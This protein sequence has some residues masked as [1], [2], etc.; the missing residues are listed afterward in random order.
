MRRTIV[1]TLVTAG[2][3]IP[4]IA[5]QRSIQLPEI[6]IG[7]DASAGARSE[8]C[9]EVEIGN[10]RAYN[11]LNQ[12]LKKEVDRVNPSVN[13]PPVDARSP[14]IRV[15]VVNIP[16][17]QQQY[18]KNFGVSVMPHR[19]ALPTFSPPLGRR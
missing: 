19:P 3:G 6:V 13:M 10:S 16:A 18:G 15:G 14:D 12:K 5:E 4:A 9:V 17:V 7:G 2:L 1:V 11:C 8:N